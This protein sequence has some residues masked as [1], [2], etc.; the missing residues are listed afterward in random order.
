MNAVF[1][2]LADPNRRALL[3]ALPPGAGHAGDLARS[4]GLAPS[5]LS[6]HLNALKSADLV[7]DSRR[8]Q[9][10]FYALN[11]SV[12]E[13]LIAF[14]L[15]NFSAPPTRPAQRAGENPGQQRD[16]RAKARRTRKAPCPP[17]SSS[18]EARGATLH[19]PFTPRRCAHDA[20]HSP[21]PL[22]RVARRRSLRSPPPS[23]R[24]SPTRADAT[25]TS[26]GR[27]TR[28][29]P[30]WIDAALLP[31][32]TPALRPCWCCCPAWGR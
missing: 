8:G 9:F 21:L 27:R 1:K 18:R 6:F 23:T 14:V 12:L 5:A 31:A 13:D 16:A 3:A 26:V 15:E 17:Q 22:D 32:V 7:T 4:L 29:G 25:G 28:F 2:A 20:T 19:K 11:T 24:T 10:V 30:R